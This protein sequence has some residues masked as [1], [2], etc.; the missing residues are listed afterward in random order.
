MIILCVD[1]D[2]EDREIFFE[3]V[4]E[5]HPDVTLITADDGEAA[6][7]LLTNPMTGT[8]DYIFLDIN[9]P[10]MDGIKCL[11]LIKSNKMLK[12]I[13]VVVYSTT[14]NKA[15]IAKV[16][17]LGASF[18]LKESDYQRLIHNIS[19]ILSSKRN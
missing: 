2:P 8:P 16:E 11:T 6:Y 19:K 13:P 12:D 1:D 9:M 14:S 15:E 4:K 3:A 17:S 18:L 7:A 10:L 5:S